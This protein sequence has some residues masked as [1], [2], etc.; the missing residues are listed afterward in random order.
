[1]T[2]T[3]NFIGQAELRD[4]DGRSTGTSVYKHKKKKKEKEK[5]KEK[6]KGTK[7]PLFDQKNECVKGKR[8]L[9]NFEVDFLVALR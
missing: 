5:E 4:F 1:M 3:L 2:H 6:E 9:G 7:R 8:R